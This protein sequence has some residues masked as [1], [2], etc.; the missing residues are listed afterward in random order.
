MCSFPAATRPDRRFHSD[1]LEPYGT[2]II[3][4]SVVSAPR[5]PSNLQI[6]L[7]L[8]QFDFNF[9]SKRQRRSRCW[10]ARGQIRHLMCRI[11]E[12]YAA[13]NGSGMVTCAAIFPAAALWER[14]NAVSRGNRFYDT[15]QPGPPDQAA[16]CRLDTGPQGFVY[17]L[18]VILKPKS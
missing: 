18:L 6:D 3:T 17:Q 13:P 4:A 14:L 15:L 9:E 12:P 10:T 11:W 1:D 2:Q 7:K 5:R 8:N 16:W